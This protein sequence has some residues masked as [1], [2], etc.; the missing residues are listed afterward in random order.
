[1][2]KF[3]KSKTEIVNFFDTLPWEVALKMSGLSL[4]YSHSLK[5]LG[6]T[7]EQHLTF[8]PHVDE[9]I[10]KAKALLMQVNGLVAM[11]W[12]PTPKL[13]RH[14]YTSLIRP[15]IT[16]GCHVWAA[17]MNE[18]MRKQLGNLNRLAALCT[19]PI[20]HR[21]SGSCTEAPGEMTFR[22]LSD[23]FTV[24]SPYLKC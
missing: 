18:T 20:L 7:L 24:F 6:V 10:K 17:K 23:F 9:K 8:K 21:S 22:S 14:A 5:F 1:M 2:G 19:A 12:G 3:N 13:I 4:K 15:T 11:H 16:Y